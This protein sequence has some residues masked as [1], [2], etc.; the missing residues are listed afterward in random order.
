[1]KTNRFER[2]LGSVIIA[3]LLL[4]SAHFALGQDYSSGST[5][6]DGAFNP[7]TGTN[8]ILVRPGGVYHYTTVNIPSGSTVRYFRSSDN[9]PVVILAQGNVTISGTLIVSGFAGGTSG[10]ATNVISGSAGGPGGFEGGDG[11]FVSSSPP[12]NIPPT[13]GK[14]PGGGA[15]STGNGGQG[16]SYAAPTAFALTPLFGGSGGGGGNGATTNSGLSGAG[17]GGAILIASS[18]RIAIN[19][20]IQ[21]NGGNGTNNGTACTFQ[22]GAGSGGAIRLVAPEIVGTGAIQ[23]VRGTS[24]NCA[25]MSLASDGR[26]RVEAFTTGNFTGTATPTPSLATAPGPVSPAGNPALTNVPTLE[27]ASIGGLPVPTTPAGSYS[28]ADVTLPLGTVNPI[29]VVLNATNTPVGAPTVITVRLIPRGSLSAV[30]V[31]SADHTGTFGNSIATTNVNLPVGQV[32]VLQAH[33][34]MTLTGETASLFPMIDGEPVER[35]VVAAELGQS[36]TLRLVTSSGR[37]VPVERLDP[38]DRMRVALAWEAMKATR[39]E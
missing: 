37:E 5:G 20:V 36:S 11:G 38:R 39:K 3:A 10:G 1:M 24:A 30:V 6:A 19:G 29:P 28:V 35:V 15:A 2:R 31:Q 17:G 34:A 8:N 12:L 4:G 25:G 18:T 13:G 22:G 16:G 7:A 26:I 23:A 32:T 14:G 33:A 21:A 9:A 27:F